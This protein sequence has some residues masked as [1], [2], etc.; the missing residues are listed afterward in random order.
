MSSLKFLWVQGYRAVEAGEHLLALSRPYL[1]IEVSL[2]SATQPG[3]LI[4]HYTTVGPRDD[5]PKDVTVLSVHSED[6]LLLPN[7]Y[8]AGSS[9]Q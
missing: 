4:A 3:Q 1:N 9:D 7:L 2:A 6:G 8:S 5:Y